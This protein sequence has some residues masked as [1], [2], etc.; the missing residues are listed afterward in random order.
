MTGFCSII[1]S[2]VLSQFPSGFSERVLYHFFYDPGP[3][4]D[5][6]P[7]K[8]PASVLR[9][10]N[11][12]LNTFLC[13]SVFSLHT[14]SLNMN[15]EIIL[16]S[17]CSRSHCIFWINFLNLFEDA[18]RRECWEDVPLELRVH[19]IDAIQFLEVVLLRIP[20]IFTHQAVLGSPLFTP[21]QSA[22]SEKH[23]LWQL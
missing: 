11:R 22:E 5:K 1:I 4:N 10:F 14:M 16:S 17:K 12:I 2:A 23:R 19:T 3:K 15:R 18:Q 7:Q 8:E 21:I 9:N 20:L 6:R 13:V